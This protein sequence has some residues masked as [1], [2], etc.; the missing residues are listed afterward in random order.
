ME[1]G[2]VAVPRLSFAVEG[3]APLAHAAAPTLV[4]TIA[5]EE[6]AGLPVR[7]VQLDVQVQIAARR[8]AYDAEAHE[9][10]FELF[11]P[12]AGWGATLR[13]LLWTRT[14]LV[15]PPFTGATA[16]ELPIPCSYDMEVLASKYF[17]ALRDGAVPLELLFSGTVFYTAPD[18]RLQIGRISWEQEAGYA[19]PVAVWRETMERHFPG[20]AWV[21]LDKERFDRLAAFKARNALATWE[22]AIDAL[23]PGGGGEEPRA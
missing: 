15:V 19:L 10:L 1:T 12:V 20:A 7:F 2:T 23:L 22:D 16:V 13:T 9:R 18:G 4:F 17:D 6:A 8:R 11:G 14:T 5:I 21:R 3:A